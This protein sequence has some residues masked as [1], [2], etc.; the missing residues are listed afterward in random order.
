MSRA[1][2][3]QPPAPR[4]LSAAE[5]AARLGVKV[6]TVYAYVSRGLLA[7]HGSAE[8]GQPPEKQSRFAAADVERLATRGRRSG[9]L[10]AAPL[11]VT[12]ELTEIS[13][14]AVYYRGRS[15]LEL[16]GQRSF[17]QI[18]EWLWGVP[19]ADARPFLASKPAVAL[20]HSVQSGMPE[21]ALPLERL[22]V[23]AAVLGSADVLRYDTSHAPVVATARALIAGMVESL[24]RLGERA[25]EAPALSA[26]LW[27][28]LT[29]VRPNAA[30]LRALDAALG[31]CA[32]H[33]L[34][35]STLAVRIAAS[36]RAD[37]YSLVQTGLGALGG[38]LHGAAALSAE[39]LLREVEQ[40]GEPSQ[41]IG[42]R[43]RRGERIA[44]FGHALH[45]QGDPRASAL[46][47]QLSAACG[48]K[49]LAAALSIRE[50]MQARGLP[51]ANIDFALAA[52]AHAAQMQPGASEAIMAIARVAGWIA[53]ALEEYAR[54]SQFPWHT[55]YVGPRAA[56][57]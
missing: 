48:A 50:I 51:A 43:L 8:P 57:A 30:R 27:T 17:E 36:Q 10:R 42:Q 25:H 34:S 4:L 3:T 14:D 49:Q 24:P 1:R 38:A 28:R 21:D 40:G 19:E 2:Q 5:A 18:A 6:E 54:P 9:G 13:A 56:S 22:R 11:L 52:L 39:E 31:L 15:A 33:A 23:I 16:A 29:R 47:A 20:A 7:R 26:R 44:G 37:P 45:P 46:F 32:D 53:H 41:L 55:L 12:S 35:P